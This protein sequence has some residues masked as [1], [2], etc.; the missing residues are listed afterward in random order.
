MEIITPQLPRH[1]LPVMILFSNEELPR[2]ANG[3]TI[4]KDLKVQLGKIWE[5]RNMVKAKL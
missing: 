5:A 4:K 1:C 2:N 3:K